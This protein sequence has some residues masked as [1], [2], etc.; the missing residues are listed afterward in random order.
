MQVQLPTLNI[1]D[2]ERLGLGLQLNGT[3]LPAGRAEIKQALNDLV[4]EFI[5]VAAEPV[6]A[7]TA[8]FAVPD[9]EA[10]E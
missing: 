6:N 9:E 4:F 7:M 2:E 5:R 3:L 10:D 8:V 1:T